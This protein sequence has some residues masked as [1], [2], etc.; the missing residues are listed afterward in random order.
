MQVKKINNN[1]YKKLIMY[2][3]EICDK[4]ELKKIKH[5]V[6]N[7]EKKQEILK[8]IISNPKFTKE[9]LI[10]NYSE[11]TLDDI[12]FEYKDDNRF[13]CDNEIRKKLH[14]KNDVEYQN[15]LTKYKKSYINSIIELF[16]YNERCIKFL[17]KYENNIIDKISTEY[18]EYYY[19]KMD[20]HFID[21]F[22]N[23]TDNI[24]DF[25]FPYNLENLCIYINDDIWLESVADDK[26]CFINCRTEE[27]YEKLKSFGINFVK[28]KHKKELI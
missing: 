19:F 22:M 21:F 3:Y 9:N 20:K 28:E 5:F 18:E 27:E 10:K 14:Y 17:E 24:Y 16:L 1:A 25:T 13:F 23:E 15:V 4:V 11:K 2:A 26:L 8:I 12:Y 7:K 6:V